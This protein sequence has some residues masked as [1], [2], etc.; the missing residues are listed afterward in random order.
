MDARQSASVFVGIGVFQLLAV[1][2]AIHIGGRT[3]ERQI[4]HQIV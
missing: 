3:R 2:A 1:F 4:R